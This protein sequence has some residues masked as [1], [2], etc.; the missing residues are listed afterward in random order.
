MKKLNKHLF[1]LFVLVTF[2]F[3]LSVGYTASPSS[4]SKTYKVLSSDKSN[5]CYIIGKFAII[6]TKDITVADDNISYNALDIN[7]ESSFSIKIGLINKDNNQTYS[8]L[9][10]LTI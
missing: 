1:V 6:H 8:F 9:L 10:K 3:S 7:H 2:L 5:D 4:I